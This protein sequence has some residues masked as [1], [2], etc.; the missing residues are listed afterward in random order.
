MKA[1]RADSVDKI[2]LR[3]QTFLPNIEQSVYP[4]I[5]QEFLIQYRKLNR[6]KSF[7]FIN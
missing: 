5:E 4:V 7:F 6:Y 2:L 3:F 1:V